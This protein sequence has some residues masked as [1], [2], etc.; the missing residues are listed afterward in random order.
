MFFLQTKK[1]EIWKL[2]I[3][4]FHCP[5]VLHIVIGPTVCN[6]SDKSPVCYY[7]R[8]TGQN[9]FFFFFDFDLFGNI[10]T[11]AIHA[12]VRGSFPGL[13]GLKETKMFLPHPLVP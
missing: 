13:G 7:P 3:F 1:A 4:L 6:R 5:L 12:R 8:S 11:A 2:Y 10:S 9:D